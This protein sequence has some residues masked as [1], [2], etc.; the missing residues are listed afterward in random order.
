ADVAAGRPVGSSGLPGLAGMTLAASAPGA[1][2]GKGDKT[3]T[4][5]P[6]QI[7]QFN[8]PGLAGPADALIKLWNM[9]S[10]ERLS[11]AMVTYNGVARLAVPAGNYYAV[12]QF[13]DYDAQGNP[14]ALRYVTGGFTVAQSDQATNVTYSEAS[15][16]ALSTVATPKPA[17][18]VTQFLTWGVQGADGGDWNAVTAHDWGPAGSDTQGIAGASIYVTPTKTAPPVGR[19]HYYIQWDGIAPPSGGSY[20]YPYETTYPYRY[21]VAFGWDNQIPPPP[22]RVLPRQLATVQEH[23]YADPALAPAT[24]E[25]AKGPVD[26]VLPGQ[27]AFAPSDLWVRPA[28]GD[29]TD[30]VG[31]A[32]G[33]QWFFL[34]NIGQPNQAG[35]QD[36]ADPRTY[37]GGHEYS[38]DWGRGPLSPQWGQH[39]P[40]PAE[41][42]LSCEACATESTTSNYISAQYPLDSEDTQQADQGLR[43]LNDTGACYLNGT[44]VATYPGCNDYQPFA[45]GTAPPNQLN[46]Y[47]LVL[48]TNLSPYG[49]AYSQSTSTHTDLTFRFRYKAKPSPEMTLPSGY[50]CSQYPDA[51]ACEILPVLRMSYQLAEDEQNASSA[52]V[53]QM[54]LDVGHQTYDG[55]GSHAAITSASVAVSF[56]DGTTW[57]PAVLVGRG[58]HYEAYWANPLSARG[59]SPDLKVTA[60]DA[61]GGSITQTIKDAYNVGPVKAAATTAPPAAPAP[62]PVAQP[63]VQA[64]RVVPA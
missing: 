63:A 24:F 8:T 22:Y 16:S 9:D 14:L 52:P 51:G 19:L 10:F 56:D 43:I 55:K 46:T 25:F 57:K 32:N 15:A 42:Y 30:Y 58:G 5:Y 48:D 41:V 38:I 7:V 17:L 64:P 13:I 45:A 3:S 2:A 6:Y 44:Q 59:T 28:P 11:I 1:T 31:T 12:T 27:A 47:R 40:R 23:V 34:S 54:T 33:G 60:T 20:P 39:S 18:Q 35:F 29:F 49:P 53:Q 50:Q 4:D 21:D 62:A 61:I 36:L 37:V 26:P